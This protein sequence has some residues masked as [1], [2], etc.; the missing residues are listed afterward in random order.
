MESV[1]TIRLPDEL[2]QEMEKYNINWSDEIRKEINNKIKALKLLATLKKMQ[3]NA[4]QMKV[5]VDSTKLVR[6]DRDSR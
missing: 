3:K 6:E 2:K 1:I 5:K 4:K